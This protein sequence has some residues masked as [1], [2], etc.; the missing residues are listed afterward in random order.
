MCVR[1]KEMVDYRI[2]APKDLAKSAMTEGGWS[3]Y[4]V[5]PYPWFRFWCQISII[6]ILASSYY[7]DV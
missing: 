7:L 4:L 3:K 1:K 5:Y 6:L 2:L